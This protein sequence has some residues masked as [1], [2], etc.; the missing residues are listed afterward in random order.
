MSEEEM[1]VLRCLSCVAINAKESK[2]LPI[3]CP[4]T[5]LPCFMLQPNKIQ[6]CMAKHANMSIRSGKFGREPLHSEYM[7]QEA[8]STMIQK[9]NELP[10]YHKQTIHY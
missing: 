9:Y 1:Y 8:I 5:Q 3:L 7:D 4:A 6:Q 10:E 2:T